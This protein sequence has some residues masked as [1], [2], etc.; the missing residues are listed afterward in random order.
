MIRLAII[1]AGASGL[2]AAYALHR[3]AAEA[4]DV[5]V[6]EKSRGVSG[7][8]AT[9]GQDG[10]RYD[11]GANYFKTDDHPRVDRLVRRDLPTEDL[12]DIGRDVW[13]FD[14]GGAISEGDP[15]H[16]AAPKW[17]YRSGISALGKLL[18]GAAETTLHLE[19]RV[20]RLARSEARWTIETTEGERFEAFDAVLLTPPAPQTAALLEASALGDAALQGRLTGA[21]GAATYRTQLTAVLAYDYEIERPGDFYALLNADGAHDIAWLSFERDKPGHVPPGQDVLIAQMAPAWSAPR[22]RDPLEDLVPQV[23]DL[24]GELLG[25]DLGAPAWADRQG[26]RYALPD[27]DGVDAEAL[28]DGRAAGLFFCGDACAGKGRVEAALASGLDA[29]DAIRAHADLAS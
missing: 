1:G 21:L 3:E 6:F 29:A 14:E 15:S 20:Q 2:A 4:I 8:A 11:H 10:V 23:T 27:G 18:A 25:Y 17:T 19:T 7:R 24:T 13:T 22:F 28:A 5:T 9:R 12:V 16:N 26:W